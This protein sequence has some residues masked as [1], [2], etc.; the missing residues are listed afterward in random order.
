M[1]KSG[2]EVCMVGQRLVA[3]A[4]AL[5]VV[6]IVLNSSV[7]CAVGG[8]HGAGA[9]HALGG[10][11]GGCGPGFCGGFRPGF[12]SFYGYGYPGWWGP[13]LGFGLGLGLG[14]GLGYGY[15]GYGYGGYPYPYY[16]P[17][18]A[19]PV[20]VTPPCPPPTGAAPP[21]GAPPAGPPPGPVR[22]TETD[23]LFSIRVPPEAV[24]KI[25]GTPTNQNGL[26]REFMSSG[27][28]PGRTYTY[29]VTAHWTG[30]DGQAVD[31]ERR[32]SVQGGERRNVDFLTPAVH[33]AE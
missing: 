12:R 9:G 29:T 32:I 28:L 15:G 5:A 22:L 33:S 1:R 16:P 8:G 11:H 2:E 6:G 3:L 24:V 7:A 27:L 4:G 25:N 13:G 30:Q 10:F 21:G 18:Y 20:Y 31:L 19:Y 26:R 14:Y 23:V 17:A